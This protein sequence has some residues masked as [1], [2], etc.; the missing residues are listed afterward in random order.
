MAYLNE[1]KDGGAKSTQTKVLASSSVRMIIQGAPYIFLIYTV[2]IKT[3]GILI[4]Y[5]IPTYSNVSF[6]YNVLVSVTCL[7]K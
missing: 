2:S 6:L 5:T 3:V 1:K 7:E 4:L